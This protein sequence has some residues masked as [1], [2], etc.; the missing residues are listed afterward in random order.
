MQAFFLILTFLLVISIHWQFNSNPPKNNC[1]KC[2]Y[3]STNQTCKKCKNRICDS[4]KNYENQIPVCPIC[5]GFRFLEKT[6]G[7]TE[8]AF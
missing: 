1:E 5:G 7:K 2:N 4:C 3:F 6:A 8:N